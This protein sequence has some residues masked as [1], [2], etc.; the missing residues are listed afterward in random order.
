MIYLFLFV[1]LFDWK[2]RKGRVESFREKDLDIFEVA[3]DLTPN[4]V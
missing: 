3:G 4:V 2:L 1:K